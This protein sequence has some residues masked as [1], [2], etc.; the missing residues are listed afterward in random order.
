MNDQQNSH[1]ELD[2]LSIVTAMI[3]LSYA[4]TAFIE[5][6]DQSLSLQLPGFLFEIKLSIYTIVSVIVAVLAAAGSAWINSSHPNATEKRTWYHW[7]IPSFTALVIGFPLNTLEVGLAWWVIFGMGGFLLLAVLLA[8]YI[9]V[10][11]NDRFYSVACIALTIVSFSLFLILAITIRGSGS[12]LYGVLSTLVPAAV[13]LTVRVLH[14]R[15]SGQWCLAWAGGISLI[16]GQVVVGL[17]YLPLKPIHF[18]LIL[19]GLVYGLISLAGNF[20][21]DYVPGK[22]WREPVVVFVIFLAIAFLF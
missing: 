12:R 4:M 5:L 3:L 15:L 22:I 20:E 9:S 8:E 6:P 1:P 21:E 16:V 14:L 13:L 11:P 10:D 2:R 18:G 7:I 17:F 19:T